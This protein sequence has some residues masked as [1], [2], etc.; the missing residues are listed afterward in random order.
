LSSA[1]REA[2]ARARASARRPGAPPSPS[3]P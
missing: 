2:Y 3:P 1:T